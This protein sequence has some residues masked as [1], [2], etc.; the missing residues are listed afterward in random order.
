[1]TK[2]SLVLLKGRHPGLD[3]SGVAVLDLMAADYAILD[4][5]DV[6]KCSRSS[7]VGLCTRPR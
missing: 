6:D 7:S 2:E 5:V 1:M 3:V 4:V